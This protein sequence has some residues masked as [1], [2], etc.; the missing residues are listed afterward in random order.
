MTRHPHDM[1]MQEHETTPVDPGAEVPAADAA[2]LPGTPAEPTGNAPDPLAV[3]Q[4]AQAEIAEL[5]DA[6]LRAK[7]ETENVRR[8]SSIDVAKAH[9][10]GIETFAA[11]LLA[12]KDS[13]E[14]AL[15]VEHATPEQLRGG[16]ELTLRQLA[17]AFDRA[18]IE[19]IDPAG[20][21]FDPHRHQAV[22]VVDAAGPPNTVVQVF[23]KGYLLND[24][25]IRPAL[26]TV[27]RND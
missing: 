23:Q 2:G 5:K 9:K 3:L 7:A 26:V 24:R 12:V 14:Q 1:T 13:L 19:D 15:A 18:R 17:A 11:D 8:Q 10:F 16:V 20:Q 22:Q 25:V 6:W 4:Q 21:P 27:S